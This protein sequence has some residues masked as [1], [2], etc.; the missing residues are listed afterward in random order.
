MSCYFSPA[1]T[2]GLCSG[3]SQYRGFLKLKFILLFK[4][5][6][7]KHRHASKPPGGLDKTQSSGAP[8]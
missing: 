2:E 8:S 1:A 6:V 5:V 7:F 3:G 4:S